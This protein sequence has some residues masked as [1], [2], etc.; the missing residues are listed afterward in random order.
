MYFYDLPKIS[1]ADD[2]SIIKTTIEFIKKYHRFSRFPI[3]VLKSLEKKLFQYLKKCNEIFFTY[4][5][6]P[7]QKYLIEFFAFTKS[8]N[9]RFCYV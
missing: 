6:L 1:P 7:Y 9:P 5:F 2:S 8:K 3:L 4:W